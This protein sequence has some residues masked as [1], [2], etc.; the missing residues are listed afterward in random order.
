MIQNADTAWQTSWD[1]VMQSTCEL[2]TMTWQESTAVLEHKHWKWR[3]HTSITI[4]TV[5][6]STMTLHCWSCSAKLIWKRAFVLSVYPPEEWIMRLVRDVQSPATATWVNQVRIFS[7]KC[8]W[9]Y[10]ELSLFFMQPRTD[11]PA[12]ARSWDS[13]RQWLRVYKKD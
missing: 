7:S 13:N 6:R 4:T 12:S 2:V 11:S 3:Q 9:M 5:K 8:I 1:L 10:K